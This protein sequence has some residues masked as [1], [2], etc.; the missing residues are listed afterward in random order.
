MWISKKVYDRVVADKETLYSD[1]LSQNRERSNERKR[2]E[3]LMR[4]LEVILP[5]SI[6]PL[7]VS[8][9][10]GGQ[11]G[12]AGSGIDEFAS[13]V[14]RLTATTDLTADAAGTA[15]GRTYRESRWDYSHIIAAAEAVRNA[16]NKVE[17]DALVELVNRMKGATNGT[18]D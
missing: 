5:E 8:L 9:T 18:T 16:D 10:L 3:E 15:L 6:A 11:L 2:F 4:A 12:I 7:V 13:V 1:L 17:N 14:A